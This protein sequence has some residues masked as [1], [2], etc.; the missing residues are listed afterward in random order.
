LVTVGRLYRSTVADYSTR[1]LAERLSLT[2]TLIIVQTI[3]GFLLSIAFIGAAESFVANFVPGPVRDV[4]IQYVRVGAFG[5]CLAS[6]VETAV[7]TSMR[8]LDQPKCVHL[9]PS[10]TF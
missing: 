7:S 5:S 1:S 3:L 10:L 9:R 4:S 2:R 8:A 6:T